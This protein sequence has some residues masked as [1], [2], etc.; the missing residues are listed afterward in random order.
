M[1][2]IFWQQTLAIA[3]SFSL[4]TLLNFPKYAF[5]FVKKKKKL[6]GNA[7][8]LWLWLQPSRCFYFIVLNP[9]IINILFLVFVFIW[10]FQMASSSLTQNKH[11]PSS[12]PPLGVLRLNHRRAPYLLARD[13][14]AGGGTALLI[15]THTLNRLPLQWTPGI[16][17]SP[18]PRKMQHASVVLYTTR[19]YDPLIRPGKRALSERNNPAKVDQR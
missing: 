6:I 2:T 5:Y 17:Y 13:G 4:C 14:A 1:T 3:I 16:I 18:S 8:S 10:T 9:R 19:P 11:F 15:L 7:A 12:L